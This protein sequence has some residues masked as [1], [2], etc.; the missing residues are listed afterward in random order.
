MKR[1][2]NFRL[3]AALG[4]LAAMPAHAQLQPG[5]VSN[6][7]PLGDSIT[8][9]SGDGYGN[10]RRPLQ[11]LLT[12]GGYSAQF[13]GANTEQSYNYSGTDPGQTFNPYQ[14]NHEGYGLLRIDQIGG[15]SPATD[16]GGVVYP[17][18]QATIASD[19]PGIILLM[20]GTNDV[21]QNY[22]PGRPG[23]GGATGFGADA[24][25]RLNTLVG[26]IFTYAP[27][28]T[29]VLGSITP[30]TDTT[31]EAQGQSYNAFI[32]QIASRYNGLGDHVVFADMHAALQNTALYISADGTHPTTAGYDR[33]AQTWYSAL[34]AAPEPSA[35]TSLGIGFLT[36]GV[37]AG[38]AWKKRPDKC[39][40]LPSLSAPL[41][42]NH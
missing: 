18:L 5:T 26:S 6:I 1:S 37:L 34:T 41:T 29:V 42:S 7:M 16:D 38:M 23:Y 31:L 8:R 30:R 20:I 12:N 35:M 4:M 11:S 15:N 19:Q 25:Q 10:Y 3:F 13:V 9:G 33:M 36:L 27:G 17:G 21:T 39:A 32:P 2:H 24:A 28:V 14:P 22:D 40:V